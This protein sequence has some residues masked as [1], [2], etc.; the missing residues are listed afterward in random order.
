MRPYRAILAIT[1]C[2]CLSAVKEE[3][4]APARSAPGNGAVRTSSGDVITL[5][6]G[7]TLEGFQILEETPTDYVVDILDGTIT[8]NIP[9]RQVVSVIYDDVDPG[10]P[11]SRMFRSEDDRPRWIAARK[12]P[13]LPPET[14]RK[15]RKNIGEPSLDAYEGKDIVEV[16]GEVA[17]R[18]DLPI[19]CGQAVLKMPPETRVWT[20]HIGPNTPLLTFLQED[21]PK[22]KA[23]D[24][25][26]VKGRIVVT[27]PAEA[28][29][30]R[31]TLGATGTPAKEAPKNQ[32]VEPG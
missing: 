5:K 16:L 15:L 12:L 11:H 22:W 9:R 29:R 13:E 32:S 8:L 4:R 18:A 19:E 3:D 23:F 1:A 2:V 17:K 26:Y 20:G 25:L 6:S 27:T 30:L 28:K 14:L 31:S 7:R 10:N 21:L 24:W